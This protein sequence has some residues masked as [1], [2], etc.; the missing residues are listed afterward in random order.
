MHF[1]AVKTL[2][3]TTSFQQ[4]HFTLRFRIVLEHI[5]VEKGNKIIVEMPNKTLEAH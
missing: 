2:A 4:M 5:D 1:S 3:S